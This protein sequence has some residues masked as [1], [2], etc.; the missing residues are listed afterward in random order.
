MQYYHIDGTEINQN[1]LGE[2]LDFF[3]VSADDLYMKSKTEVFFLMHG[4][5]LDQESRCLNYQDFPRRQIDGC[6]FEYLTGSGFVRIEVDF[7]TLVIRYGG[8][9]YNISE[10]DRGVLK[11]GLNDLG[12][13]SVYLF[14]GKK[15]ESVAWMEIIGTDGGVYPVEGELSSYEVFFQIVDAIVRR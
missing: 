15:D 4:F 11:Q 7:P 5:C 2:F 13:M 1:K 10:A 14:D 12:I 9:V 8:K 3:E 6:V